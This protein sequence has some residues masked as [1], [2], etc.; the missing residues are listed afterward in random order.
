MGVAGQYAQNIVAANSNGSGK[1]RKWPKEVLDKYGGWFLY[2]LFVSIL[3]L[4]EVWR[5]DDTGCLSGW[6]LVL[7][8][9]GAVISSVLFEKRMWCSYLC[10]I[11]GMLGA[12]AKLAPV[13]LRGR[14]GVCSAECDS[15]A[16]I[17]G[18]PSENIPGCPQN[19]HCSH[20]SDNRL[21]IMCFQCIKNC[22]NDSIQ[23]N[24]RI[25]GADLWEGKHKPLDHEVAL[26]F[27]LF[28]AVV[29]HD[30]APFL[31]MLGIADPSP[32]VSSG[33]DKMLHTAAS[34]GI[35]SAPGLVAWGVDA[36]WRRLAAYCMSKPAPTTTT[37][38]DFHLVTIS[39]DPDASRA[40]SVL[41]AAL[42][43]YTSE[44]ANAAIRAPSKPFI[45]IA[46]GYLPLAW[47][48][49]LAYYLDNLLIEG[50]HILQ[51]AASTFGFDTSASQLLPYFEAHPAVISAMQGTLLFFGCITS[52]GMTLRI[53]KQPARV[54]LPQYMTI[55]AFSVI[56][57]HTILS[58]N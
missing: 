48:S 16:C 22:P 6:L 40:I 19:A 30:S 5:L 38:I 45:D 37:S 27:L 44:Q 11:G 12:F 2:S 52:W 18:N 58:N 15:Y 29:L 47:A 57:G 51:S 49:S 31:S 55:I 24:L 7:I 17:K 46:Y 1:L 42:S 8:T 13:E 39:Q 28:G 4:E 34:L 26:I 23:L 20:L 10:P 3:V 43:S 54:A 56:F 14:P 50:G 21:C 41:Q 36:A 32:F 9:T 25:P 53:T 33:S 35:L